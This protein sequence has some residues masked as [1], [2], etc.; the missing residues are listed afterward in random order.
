MTCEEGMK[1]IGYKGCNGMIYFTDKKLQAFMS[2]F[3]VTLDDLRDEDVLS[4]IYG[5]YQF[6]TNLELLLAL[7]GQN[8]VMFARCVG[9]NQGT[10]S[11]ILNPAHKPTAGMIKKISKYFNISAR[12]LLFGHA[13]VKFEL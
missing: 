2:K 12:R 11:Y 7:H 6:P 13:N 3:K 1:C 8:K 4:R 10:V 9:I 5:E